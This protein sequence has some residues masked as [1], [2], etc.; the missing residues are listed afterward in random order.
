MERLPERIA[1]L[2]GLSILEG[3][4]GYG[5]AR[6]GVRPPSTFP[7]GAALRNAGNATRIL[8]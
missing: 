4:Q 3:F 1:H 5:Y 6:S 8:R 2:L 7:A